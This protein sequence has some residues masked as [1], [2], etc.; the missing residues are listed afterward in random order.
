MRNDGIEKKYT[1]LPYFVDVRHFAAYIGAHCA[2][3]A[4]DVG[5]SFSMSFH[6]YVHTSGS[7]FCRQLFARVANDR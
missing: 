7:I 5:I 3:C 6:S 1:G 4:R 2:H